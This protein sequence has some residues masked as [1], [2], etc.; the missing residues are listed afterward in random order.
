[1][2]RK[3]IQARNPLKIEVRNPGKRSP[4]RLSTST[5]YVQYSRGIFWLLVRSNGQQS[6]T[7]IALATTCFR[8]GK[9]QKSRLH[10]RSQLLIDK[11]FNHQWCY[12]IP[13]N[14]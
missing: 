12:E 8:K 3:S 2:H 14:G 7:E 6:C 10:S 1:M 11:V 13:S 9:K 5:L 4:P